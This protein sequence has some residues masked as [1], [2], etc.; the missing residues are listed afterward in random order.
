MHIT[1]TPG[2]SSRKKIFITG[3]A[4]FIGFHLALYLQ[5]R[6]DLVTGCDNFNTYYEPSLKQARAK[7]LQA[8]GIPVLDADICLAPLLSSTILSYGTTHIVHLAAQAGVRHSLQDPNSYVHSNLNGFVQ[9]LEICKQQPGVRFIYASSASVYGKN[10]KVPFSETDITDLPANFYGATKKAGE[11]IAQSYHHMFKIPVTGL[12]YFSVYGP[13]GR[14]DMAYFSFTRNILEGKP[15]QLYNHGKMKRDFTYIDDIVKG[16]AAAIDLESDCEIFN[17]GH[18]QPQELESMVSHLEDLLGKKAVKDYL[19]MQP[20]EVEETY[21]DI[22]KSQKA[23]N[24]QP[25]MPFQKGLQQFVDWYSQY[26]SL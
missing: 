7:K 13:W 8:S 21:A 6:G 23:L 16:T 18:H 4:G 12:R 3:I 19:P 11:L 24:F 26:Y 14:P 17:L 25:A 15:I 5:K 22:A 9:M 1:S 20:G 10:K 2:F